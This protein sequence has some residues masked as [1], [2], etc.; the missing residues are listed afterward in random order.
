MSKPY[1]S[2]KIAPHDMGRTFIF[3]AVFA[4]TLTAC[5]MGERQLAPEQL[6]ESELINLEVASRTSI[7]PQIQLLVGAALA[8][9]IVAYDPVDAV[10]VVVEVD[11]G[12]IR[13]IVN[14]PN[15]EQ[16]TNLRDPNQLEKEIARTGAVHFPMGSLMTPL[17]VARAVE[18]GRVRP[19]T[20]LDTHG[21]LIVGST[22]ITDAHPE[23]YM[24][25]SDIVVKSSN[26]GS[27]KIALML[28]LEDLSQ[29][30]GFDPLLKIS[31]SNT[32]VSSDPIDWKSWSAP[33]LVLPGMYLKANLLQAVAAYMP[34]ANGGLKRPLTIQESSQELIP[35]TR[36]FSPGTAA[37]IREILVR[38]TSTEGTAPKAMVPG[39]RVAGKTSTN[40]SMLTYQK[41]ESGEVTATSLQSAA[42]VG[43]APADHPRWLVGVVFRFQ[44][45]A[46][47]AYGGDTAAP[48]FAQI[49]KGLL[50]KDA[51]P[52]E[53]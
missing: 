33:M 8:K 47:L 37:D 23:K 46:P 45:D 5:T 16:P 44:K 29:S 9:G 40:S 39:I 2:L 25:T 19:D 49:V 53:K 21:T 18:T 38:A 52:Q 13:A 34:I 14:G 1:R 15:F 7:D 4:V 24:S 11:T 6:A 17:L 27:A 48:V 42:F 22:E 28:P 12:K 35:A 50:N 43:M 10:A 3:A 51:R 41:S 26:V 36:I 30:L 31:G 32:T 20:Q